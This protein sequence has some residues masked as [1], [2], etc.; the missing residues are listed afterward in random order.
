MIIFVYA[1]FYPSASGWSF[2]GSEACP[3]RVSMAASLR[4]GPVFSQIGEDLKASFCISCI[5]HAFGLKSS[6][7]HFG[8]LRLEE[9]GGECFLIC[10]RHDIFIFKMKKNRCY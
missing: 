7:Y 2:L 5:T 6:L 3:P 1:V 4:E 8:S 9:K 10:S